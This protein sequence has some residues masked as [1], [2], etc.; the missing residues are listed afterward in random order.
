MKNESES[1]ALK[2]RS[3]ELFGSGVLIAP[4]LVLTNNHV[5]G[6][7]STLDRTILLVNHR[8]I[9]DTEGNKPNDPSFQL[10]TDSDLD[11]IFYTSKE[12]DFTIFEID[13]VRSKKIKI[14]TGYDQL[15]KYDSSI[16]LIGYPLGHSLIADNHC[17]GIARTEYIN[18]KA[19]KY[20]FEPISEFVYHLCNSYPGSS[21]SPLYDKNG[22]LLGIHR[23]SFFQN[24]GIA[25]LNAAVSFPSIIANLKGDI[26]KISET[27]HY[28]SGDLESA[29]RNEVEWGIKSV[30]LRI[31][32]GH[33]VLTTEAIRNTK[34]YF[35]RRGNIVRALIDGNI[36]VDYPTYWGIIPK[37][38]DLYRSHYGKNQYRHAMLISNTEPD[39]IVRSTYLKKKIISYLQNE[40]NQFIYMEKIDREDA[41]RVIGRILHTIQDSYSVAHTKR[42][43]KGIN[44]FYYYKEQDKDIHSD[45]DL[46]LNLVGELKENAKLAIRQ[47]QK[48]LDAAY[49]SNSENKKENIL[50]VINDVFKL[51]LPQGQIIRSSVSKQNVKKSSNY[52]P[53]LESAAFKIPELNNKNSNISMPLPTFNLRRNEEVERP[54][55]YPPDDIEL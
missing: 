35:I 5:I 33:E 12:L 42:T 30:I 19:L 8:K 32:A 15:N 47:S 55:K 27:S 45:S 54:I 9:K 20:D 6:S 7:R 38:L 17:L 23:Q 13:P 52:L 21:G 14:A 29:A 44:D 37:P 50:V 51:D 31:S 18:E 26:F 28:S 2:N 4:N 25:E 49:N 24:N 40:A 1:G 10:H 11:R 36:S 3:T 22:K 53:N 16:Y 48:L 43:T 34:N 39:R 41:A 46:V